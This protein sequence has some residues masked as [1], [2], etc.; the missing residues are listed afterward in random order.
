MQPC[1]EFGEKKDVGKVINSEEQL[2]GV[3]NMYAQESYQSQE[4][5]QVLGRAE[6]GSGR[7]SEEVL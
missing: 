3:G 6:T 5:A 7:V 2:V 4:A 1:R